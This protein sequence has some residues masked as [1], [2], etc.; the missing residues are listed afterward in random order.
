[1]KKLINFADFSKLEMRV[2]KIEKVEIPKGSEHVYR[3]MVD[4][5]KEV[6]KKTIFAGLKNAYK[7]EELEG[8]QGIFVVNLEP[9]P[10]MGEESEAM[11][12]AADTGGVPVM[13][14]PEKEVKEGDIIR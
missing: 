7:P 13:L 12:L 5:G 4:L 10:I 11:L 14:V 1:M 6:G 2:G 8:K 3:L 9:K